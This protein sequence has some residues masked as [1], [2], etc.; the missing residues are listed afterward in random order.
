M[1]HTKA[2]TRIL[3]VGDKVELLPTNARNRQLRKQ[4]GKHDWIIVK[5][6]PATQCFNGQEGILIVSVIDKKH[7]RWVQRTD[8][9]IIEFKENL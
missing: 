5:I 1:K 4:D 3:K 8:I 6:D 7:D 9:K 2:Q